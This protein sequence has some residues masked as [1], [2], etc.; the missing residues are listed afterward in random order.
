MQ[1]KNAMTRWGCARGGWRKGEKQTI[2]SY[3]WSVTRQRLKHKHRSEEPRARQVLH[4]RT[5]DTEHNRTERKTNI[6]RARER[7]DPEWWRCYVQRRRK[8]CITS[9]W[10]ILQV[11]TS[12]SLRA[13]EAWCLVCCGAYGRTEG[14][15]YRLCNDGA[16]KF[17]RW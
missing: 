12:C 13:D 15:A 3:S 16:S 5:W 17:R 1:I 14:Y 10:N 11:A 4:T 8:K 9:E 7:H 6:K 2:A